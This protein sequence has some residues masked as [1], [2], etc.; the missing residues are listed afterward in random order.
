MKAVTIFKYVFAVIG[1]GMLVGAF[2]LFNDTRDFLKDALVTEGTV[3]ELVRSR[4]S[5]ST[6]YRP[7]VEFKTEDGSLV[8]FTSG[9]GSNPPS[10]S[11]GET[12]EVLYQQDSPEQAKINGFFSLWGLTLIVGVM[13]LIFFSCGIYNNNTWKIKEKRD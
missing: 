9:A 11:K 2:Y 1:L 6:T 12:V 3:V 10:Y 4:S 13:G 7:V 8:E 5:D